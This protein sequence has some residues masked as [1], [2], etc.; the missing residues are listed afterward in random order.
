V[1]ALEGQVVGADG[2]VG[3]EDHHVEVQPA[4]V[5]GLALQRGQVEIQDGHLLDGLDLH[6][7]RLAHGAVLLLADVGDPDV[8]GAGELGLFRPRG[9]GKGDKHRQ[10]HPRIGRH[11]QVEFHSRHSQGVQHRFHFQPAKRYW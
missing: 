8:A 9:G 7:R 5:G 2:V 3:L 1:L 4:A 11:L 6:L 10:Q